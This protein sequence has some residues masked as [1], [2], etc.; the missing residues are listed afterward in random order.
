VFLYVLLCRPLSHSLH[1]MEDTEV[2]L[3]TKDDKSRV[4]A[5]LSD[6]GVAGVTKV[7]LINLVTLK[8]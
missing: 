3:I 7:S 4:K 8:M 5:L 1:P 2:C 6:K